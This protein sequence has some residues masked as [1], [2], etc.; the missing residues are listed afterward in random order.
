MS[1]LCFANVNNSIV[2]TFVNSVADCSVAGSYIA[3]PASDYNSFASA[4][5]FSTTAVQT[6]FTFSNA[7]QLL[8]AIIPLLVLAFV[9]RAVRRSI[10]PN[11]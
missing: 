11:F 7:Q 3:I 8:T 10:F 5:T 6:V 9:F 4:Y 2:G 1:L